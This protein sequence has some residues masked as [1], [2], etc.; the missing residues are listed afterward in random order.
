MQ[1]VLITN[2]KGGVGK[3]TLTLALAVEGVR[4]GLQVCVI[5][6]DAVQ[7]SLSTLMDKR[8]ADAPHVA[9]VQDGSVADVLPE[10]QAYD[11]V[12]ID[13]APRLTL[14]V[15]QLLEAVDLVLIPI[16]ASP[17]DVEASGAIVQPVRKAGTPFAF[18]INRADARRA[19]VGQVRG[20]LAAAYAVAPIVH[21]RSDWIA[22][23]GSGLVPAEWNEASKAAAEAADLWRYVAAQLGIHA[24]G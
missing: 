9:D 12:I 13:G 8:E 18:V 6:A 23:A 10:L 14:D 20:I 17:M 3:T 11:L 19:V 7:Q 4:A 22:A 21:E 16:G 24:H 2:T 15:R 1:S 5:D